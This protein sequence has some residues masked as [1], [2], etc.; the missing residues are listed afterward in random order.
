MFDVLRKIAQTWVAKGLMLILAAAFGIWGVERSLI[1]GGGSNTVVTVGDQQIGTNEFRLAY[2]R[3]IQAISQQLRMQIT[4]EQ[5]R[6]FGIG[7]QTVAQLVAGASLDQLAADMNLGLSQ[8]RLAQLIGDDPAFKALNGSFDRQKFESLLRNSSINPDDYIK[9]RSKVA[10]RSQIVEAVS[11]GFTAPKVLV[12]AVK[13]YHDENRSIDYLLLTNANIDPIKAPAE[14][15]LQKWFDGVKPKYRAPEYRKFAY[16]TLQ[17]EDVANPASVT[18]DAVRAEF[19][20]RKDSF[21]TPATRTIE[22]LTFANKDLA[23]AAADALKT[24]STFDQLVTDQGK[25][26]ADVLLGTFTKDQVPDQTIAQAAFAVIKEGGTTPVIDGSFGPVILRVTNVKAETAKSF[27]EVKEDIRKQIALNNAA[28]EITSAHDKFEDLRG[29]GASLQEAAQQMKLKLVTVDSVDATGLDSSGNEIKDLPAK[30]QLLAEVFKADQGG[31]A[32]PLTIGNNGYV[33]YDV[34][35]ITAD[36]DRPLSEVHDKAVADWTA[37]QQKVA[38]AA[39]ATE[40]KQ[41]AQ[42]GKSLA[43]IAAPLGIAVENKSGVT[44]TT[45]DP[46]LGR[47]GV[48][49]SF[50]GP[51]DTV[52]N[53]VGADDTTQ[54]L[55]KVTEVNDNPTTDALNNADQQAAQIANAAGDDILDQMVSDL[56]SKYSVTV[57]QS[58][59]E[60]AMSR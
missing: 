8:D 42:K 23:N 24:G 3:Q 25:K 57:N 31:N 11:N 40:L 43:D 21:T 55:L 33:W 53:A 54:I 51:A 47:G 26:P 58:L 5:A 48:A 37:E 9:E 14:D 27:D 44:R 41:E 46:V 50:S 60:Q 35:N 36:H 20:K 10:I 2:R 12:D 7:Q 59:A 19:E 18:D 29:S 28:D 49:A 38:L 34:L 39:K 30:Q 56:Q 32:A 15:V 13:Q 17:A 6:A 45:D 16:V 4:P 52:A 22:Q 1:S